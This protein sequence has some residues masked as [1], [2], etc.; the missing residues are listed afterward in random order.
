MTN[1]VKYHI[2]FANVEPGM[3][4]VIYELRS[5]KG[6]V[7]IGGASTPFQVGTTLPP[8]SVAKTS[9]ESALEVVT[10]SS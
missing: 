7:T 6:E 10:T 5:S 4:T 3:Y 1:R 9:Y 2:E 8:I